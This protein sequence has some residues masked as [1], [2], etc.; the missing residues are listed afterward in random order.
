MANPE[1]LKGSCQWPVVSCQLRSKADPSV[2]TAT[3]DDTKT[4]EA[5]QRGAEE[6]VTKLDFPEDLVRA[7][8]QQLVPKRSNRI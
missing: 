4:E 1:H 7:N 8:G 6:A 3:G 5:G 2:A